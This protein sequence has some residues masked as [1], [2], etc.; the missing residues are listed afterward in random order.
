M[1]SSV[2]NPRCEQRNGSEG[3]LWAVRELIRAE[4][5]QLC[6]H[7]RRG[8]AYLHQRT[9]NCAILD[10]PESIWLLASP[11]IVYRQPLAGSTI[12]SMRD[13]SR[14]VMLW[15]RGLCEQLNTS[16]CPLNI[17]STQS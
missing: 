3:I 5:K 14:T 11:S 8:N 7:K 4:R 13:D 6:L 17:S 15:N 9:P 12:Q 10:L 2:S 16:E 1:V